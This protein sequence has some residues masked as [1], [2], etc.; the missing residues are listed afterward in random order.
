MAA[1]FIFKE[2]NSNEQGVRILS[3]DLPSRQADPYE[4]LQIPG[5]PEPMMHLQTGRSFLPITVKMEISRNADV[6]SILAW[7]TGSGDL[8]TSDD[9][10]KRYTAYACDTVSV[11]RLNGVYRTITVR[12]QCSPFAY[13]IANDP[14]ELTSSPAQLQTAGTMYS[15]PL[16]ELTGSGD[17]TLTVNGVTLEITDVS[18]TIYCQVYKLEYGAKTSI[19]SSTTGWI[20]QMVLVPDTEAVNIISWT[21][22]VTEIKITKNERW[23]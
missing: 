14:V 5:R 6:R 23:Q 16:I 20:E 18:G 2:K 17:V 9:P 21:G 22:N 1:Y 7:L 11:S 19:L 4:A 8:I 13:A 12:F 3:M 10:A 15:E